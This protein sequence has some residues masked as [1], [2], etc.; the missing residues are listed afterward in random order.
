MSSQRGNLKKGAPKYQ[1]S[2]AFKHNPKSKKTEHILGLPIH[3][4]RAIQLHVEISNDGCCVVRSEQ[5]L[6]EQK[7]EEQKDFSEQLEGLKE[8]ERRKVLRQK[9]KEEEEAYARARAERRARLGL[10]Q[11]NDFDD[12]DLYDMDLSD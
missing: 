9:K 3:G 4:K 5:Q 6:A 8:R 12:E 2:F 1:N 10:D 11:D 7:D